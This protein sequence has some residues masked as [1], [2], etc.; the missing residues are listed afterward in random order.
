MLGTKVVWK[1]CEVRRYHVVDV[2]G[3]YDGGSTSRYDM[4]STYKYRRVPG[5]T[6]YRR[7]PKGTLLLI[8]GG[9]INNG[10]VQENLSTVQY[11]TFGLY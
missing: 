5:S 1:Y 3:R 8:E 7:G 11:G 4:K 2:K 9:A 6:R 10:R